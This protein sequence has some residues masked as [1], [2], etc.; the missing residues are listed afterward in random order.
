MTA[1]A[2]RRGRGKPS[3]QSQ[4]Q[5]WLA[6]L[7]SA[8]SRQANEVLQAATLRGPGY[9]LR[10][11]TR[12]RKALGIVAVQKNHTW[13]LR[14]PRIREPEEPEDFQAKVLHKLDEVER[15]TQVPRVITEDGL[16]PII[17]G[18]V[19]QLGYGKDNETTG[20]K[21]TPLEVI[22]RINLLKQNLLGH[23][24]IAREVLAWACPDA[25]LSESVVVSMLISNSIQV[26]PK[27]ELFP[28]ARTANPEF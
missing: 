3:Q 13:Y 8:G 7:L 23:D 6:D 25:G 11:L 21:I 15:K 26:K 14:D 17:K 27:A 22:Q 4:V 18:Q 12:A 1:G 16:K 20:R 5:T 19:D 28:V 9:G 2:T 24:E 10:S